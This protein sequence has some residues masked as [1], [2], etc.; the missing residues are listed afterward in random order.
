M[1]LKIGDVVY[2]IM[3][4][5]PNSRHVIDRVTKTTAIAGKMVFNKEYREGGF[6]RRKGESSMRVVS[7]QIETEEL[8]MKFAV[9]RISIILSRYEFESLPLEVL[10]QIWAIIKQHEAEKQKNPDIE[11]GSLNGEG[12]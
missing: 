6:V 7:Y 11:S 10:R 1:E 3:L 4:R 12:D 2:G 5:K 9:L 8:K